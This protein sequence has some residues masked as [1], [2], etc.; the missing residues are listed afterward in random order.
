[1]VCIGV[2]INLH[3]LLLPSQSSGEITVKFLPWP[4]SEYDLLSMRKRVDV[5]SKTMFFVPGLHVADVQTSKG[6]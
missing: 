5:S 1:M 4:R 2:R 6:T 3:L